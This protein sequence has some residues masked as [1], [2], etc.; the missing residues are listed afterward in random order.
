MLSLLRRRD[1]ALLWTGGLDLGRRRLR[2]ARCAAV[3]RL[4]AHRLDG[5]DRRDD[6]R[7]ARA[8]HPARVLRRASSWI[9]GT[10]GGCSSRRTSCRPGWSPLLLLIGDGGRL[11]LVFV[12]AAAQATVSAFSTPAESALLPTLVPD[13][14]LV[15]ANALNALNNRL[16]RLVGVPVGGLL[17]GAAGLESVVIVDCATF[18]VAAALIAADGDARPRAAARRRTRRC[19]RGRT[20]GRSGWPA[21]GSCVASAPSRSSSSSSG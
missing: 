5:R 9:A 7:G 14:D 11:W 8:R 13:R 2:A 15:A 12:V 21:W 18:V 20:S 3:L 10:G 17:L 4:R 1:F 6:R 16:G 19:P